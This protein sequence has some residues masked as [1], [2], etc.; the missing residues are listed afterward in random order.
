[1][2]EFFS[3]VARQNSVGPEH[4]AIHK[5]SCRAKEEDQPGD[6]VNVYGKHDPAIM[7][8]R[9]GFANSFVG[10]LAD[11]FLQQLLAQFPAQEPVLDAEHEQIVHRQ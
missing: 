3:I 7:R 10:W 11:F 8:Y 9:A 5:T 2:P 6:L 1:M 4:D